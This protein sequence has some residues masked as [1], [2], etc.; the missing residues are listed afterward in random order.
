MF[1]VRGKRVQSF[2]EAESS[3]KAEILPDEAENRKAPKTETPKNPKAEILP[4]EAAIN[5]KADIA[6]PALRRFGAS[7]RGWIRSYGVSAFQ[8]LGPHL[9]IPSLLIHFSGEAWG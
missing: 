3:R 7:A 5:R 8:R 1:I 2:D 9:P 4:G 6:V